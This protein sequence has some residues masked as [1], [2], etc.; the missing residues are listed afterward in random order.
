MYVRRVRDETLDFGHRGWLLDESFIFYDRKYDS[1]WVQATGRCISG[2]FNGEQL[3]TLP[4]THTTWGEWRALHPDTLVLAKPRLLVERY[5]RDGYE[6]AYKRWGTKFGLGVFVAGGHKL[7]PLDELRKS[8]VVHDMIDGQPVLVVY[9]Q[10]SQTAVAFDPVLAGRP[11][12][13][14]VLE[15]TQ[16]DVLMR[17]RVSEV[18]W[19]GLNGRAQTG[20]SSPHQ[21]RQLRTTQFAIDKW[22][23]H[24]PIGEIY[25]SP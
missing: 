3:T 20:E 15:V 22:R 6:L 14:E 17:E 2:K 23:K 12:D 18:V 4:V 24:F 11:Q 21:L 10:P 7:Y 19:S 16:S 1:L 13:F 9:H 8:P 5:R 25:G